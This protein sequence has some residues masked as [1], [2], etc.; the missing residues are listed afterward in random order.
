MNVTNIN[1]K[2]VCV[3]RINYFQWI[4]KAKKQMNVFGTFKW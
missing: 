1:L 2:K 4:M 3:L